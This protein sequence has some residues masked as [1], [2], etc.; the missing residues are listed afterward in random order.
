MD[1]EAVL[2]DLADFPATLEL[3]EPAIQILKLS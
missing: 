1:G 3:T 2:L